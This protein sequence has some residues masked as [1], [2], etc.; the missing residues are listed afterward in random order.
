M[1]PES[2]K[3]EAPPVSPA[4]LLAVWKLIRQA[5]TQS[6]PENQFSTT[7][8]SRELQQSCGPGADVEAVA[9]RTL[10]LDI[11]SQVSP[12]WMEQ[13]NVDKIIEIAARFPFKLPQLGVESNEP[14]FDVREFMKQIAAR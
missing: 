8:Y 1:P 3:R 12:R 4:D 13:S 11:L 7:V 10:M 14:P 5:P 2:G 9:A 6:S